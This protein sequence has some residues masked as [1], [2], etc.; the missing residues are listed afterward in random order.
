MK[1]IGTSLVTN[2]AV[3]NIQAEK[4]WEYKCFRNLQSLSTSQ[5]TYEL[6]D[7]LELLFATKNH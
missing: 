5:L 1:K 6:Q 7:L 3:P 4:G 2:R